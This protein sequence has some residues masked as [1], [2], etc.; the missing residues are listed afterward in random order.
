MGGRMRA[1]AA[2]ALTSLL[3]GCANWMLAPDD[4]KLLCRVEVDEKFGAAEFMSHPLS[5]PGGAMTGA[6]GG[7]L[8]GAIIG[9]GVGAIVYAPIGAVMGAMCAAAAVKWSNC[10]ITSVRTATWSALLMISSC[11]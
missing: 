1:A 10:W 8:Q 11:N 2:L 7:A 4:R 3:V 6:A 9:A 5:N